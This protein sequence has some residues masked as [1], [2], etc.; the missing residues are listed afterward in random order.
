METE[1]GRSRVVIIGG[2][3]GGLNAARKLSGVP[4]DVTLIDRNNYHLFQPLLY[5]VATAGLEPAQIAKPI[6][7]ILRRQ[8]NLAFRMAEAVG[9]DLANRV[10]VTDDGPIPYDYLIV[11]VGAEVDHFGMLGVAE[12]GLKLKDLS[13]AVAVRNHI[14]ACFERA[15]VTKDPDERRS[16]LTF[17]LVG[18]G[19]T[20]VEM[21]GALTELVHL[22][23]VHDY[24]NLESKDVRI[25]LLEMMDH[26]LPGFAA[27]LSDSARERLASKGADVRLG[28]AVED[29]DGS[30]A[31]LADGQTIATKTLLWAAG[32]RASF[33]A[34]KLGFGTG[35]AGRTNVEGSLQLPGHPEV[36]VV[37]DAA[38]LEAGGKPLPMMAPVAIQMAERAAA[39]IRLAIKGEAP[40]AFEYHDPGRLAT[41]GRNAAVA[42][43]SGWQF[44]GFVAWLVWLVVHLIQLI[45]FRNRLVVLINWAWDYFFYERGVRL[46]SRTGDPLSPDF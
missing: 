27:G 4:V 19:P 8:D 7:A 32:V 21:A 3:F 20:G 38:Y 22:V 41:I 40:L 9:V 26:L 10:V 46:I 1:A 11:A 16:L 23:L 42:E 45:G 34:Q 6:R 43:L 35:R 31:V 12:H 15:V 36:Y 30:V 14:L 18:G 28:A 44:K 33:L 17:V 24:P 37:G 2:G 5:Q 13:D 29:Y 39:N 25:I